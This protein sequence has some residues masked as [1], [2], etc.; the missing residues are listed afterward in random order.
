M[1]RRTTAFRLNRTARQRM[2]TC[3]TK[4]T[5]TAPSDWHNVYT[6]QPLHTVVS[7]QTNLSNDFHF[8]LYLLKNVEMKLNHDDSVISAITKDRG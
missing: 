3:T 2:Y 4:R 6:A 8:G 5:R 1:P 7:V